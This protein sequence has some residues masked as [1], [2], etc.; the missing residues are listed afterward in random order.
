MPSDEDKS[1][2]DAI[3]QKLRTQIDEAH[4]KL[5]ALKASLAAA[6]DRGK[7]ALAKQR[8]ELEQRIEQHKAQLREHES[9]EQPK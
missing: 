3:K 8:Q 5:E 9:K 7:D 4:K 2:H 6:G 1:K